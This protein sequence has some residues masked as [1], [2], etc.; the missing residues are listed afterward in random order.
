MSRFNLVAALFGEGT[1]ASR[2]VY[3]LVGL[4]ALYQIIRLLF[5]ETATNRE[6]AQE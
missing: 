1:S 3:S 5:G 6:S 2:V 4:S